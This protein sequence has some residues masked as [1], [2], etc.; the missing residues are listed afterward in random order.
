MFTARVFAPTYFPTKYWPKNGAKRMSASASADI[1]LFLIRVSSTVAPPALAY[2]DVTLKMLRPKGAVQ[3]VLNSLHGQ[4]HLKMVRTRSS[5]VRVGGSVYLLTGH[6]RATGSTILTFIGPPDRVLTW[7]LMEGGGALY[8]LT[9][10]TDE[11]GRANCVYQAGGFAG[12]A[13]IQVS[14]GS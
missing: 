13:V 6:V 10:Y 3:H 4:V 2:A 14:Y 12:E 5:H 7:E 1:T 11:W 9:D 8:P